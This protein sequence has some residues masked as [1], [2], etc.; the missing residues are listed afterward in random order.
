MS[1][2]HIPR[3]TTLS[4]YSQDTPVKLLLRMKKARRAQERNDPR[5]LELDERWAKKLMTYNVLHEERMKLVERF[6][7]AV[8]KIEYEAACY[9][10]E[11]QNKEY[12][13]L[14]EYHWELFR[15]HKV[16]QHEERMAAEAAA[17]AKEE[18]MRTERLQ[19]LQHVKRLRDLSP[20]RQPMKL[21]RDT[22]GRV[23][24]VA[25]A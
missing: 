14:A 10:L 21:Q 7:E 4:K 19:R 18:Q 1:P 16:K 5:I 8:E 23:I 25:R 11:K 12:D 3:R 13:R 9:V 6:S 17:K 15:K 24:R 22:Y 20:I 2:R